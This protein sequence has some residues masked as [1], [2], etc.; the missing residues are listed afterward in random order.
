MLLAV[1]PRYQRPGILLWRG[2]GIPRGNIL[3]A[4]DRFPVR[5]PV[6]Y[7]L[8]DVETDI[9]QPAG[10]LKG[11]RSPIL[12]TRPGEKC[13]LGSETFTGRQQEST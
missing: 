13:G 8:A 1:A 6:F 11:S 12:A 9:V 3:L 10:S 7:G 2:H 4:L 5:M